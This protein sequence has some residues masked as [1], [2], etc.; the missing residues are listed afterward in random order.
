MK[1]GTW[2][3]MVFA[4]VIVFVAGCAAP[5]G[6]YARKRSGGLVYA[7]ESGSD[8]DAYAAPRG[9]KKARRRSLGG[10]VAAEEPAPEAPAAQPVP[11]EAAAPAGLRL[12]LAAAA[13]DDSKVAYVMARDFGVRAPAFRS[14]QVSE[15]SQE[16]C[17]VVATVS[18]RAVAAVSAYTRKQLFAGSASDSSLEGSAAELTSLV[19]EAFKK[20]A[21]LCEQ[22]LAERSGQPAAGA[23]APTAP[24]PPPER[25]PLTD[26]QRHD[27]ES[28]LQP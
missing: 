9:K 2:L 15:G 28:Q 3:S 20:G 21:A 16:G 23:S 25:K 24:P 27:Q 12:C 13:K 5:S 8:V 11:A 26:A 1:I 22:V 6:G 4:C 19:Y 10:M 18:G 14:V 7:Q 17:D